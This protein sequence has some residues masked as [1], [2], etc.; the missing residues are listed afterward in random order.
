MIIRSPHERNY[1]CINNEILNDYSLGLKNMALLCHLLSKPDNWNISV[2]QLSKVWGIGRDS[3]HKILNSLIEQGYA[4]RER[5][6]TGH[7]NWYISEVK[8]EVSKPF[9]EKPETLV[10]KPHTENTYQAKK[11]HTENQYQAPKQAQDQVFTPHTEN[12]YQAT[13]E[14]T[15]L[16]PAKTSGGLGLI[17]H[18]EKPDTDSKALVSNI[19]KQVIKKLLV[20]TE[21]KAKKTTA[22]KKPDFELPGWLNQNAW[23]EFEQS[24][25]EIKKPLTDLGRAKAVKI[26]E[27]HSYND[28]QT[29]ID[30]SINGRYAGLFPD[31]LDRQKAGRQSDRPDIDWQDMTWADGMDSYQIGQF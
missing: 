29:I 14:I 13:P 12:T 11:P 3:V 19:D 27:G 10:N 25:K 5:T 6:K 9:T 18:T 16:S 15:P 22:P 23:S 26:L 28:Q 7:I 21:G 1:T 31:C 2:L 8:N 17:P 4:R 20:S 30:Y 24:R